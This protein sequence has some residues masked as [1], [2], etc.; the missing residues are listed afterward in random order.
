M[1]TFI[2]YFLFLILLNNFFSFIFCQTENGNFKFTKDEL[3]TEIKNKNNELQILN[4]EYQ[5]SLID[6]KNWLDEV[7]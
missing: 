3:V 7:E 2:K 5:Q 4:Q 1:K 6:V